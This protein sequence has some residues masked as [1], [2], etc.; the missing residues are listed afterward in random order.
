[1]ENIIY[2]THDMRD[3][4]L[5][6]IFH[7]SFSI[8]RQHTLPNWHENIELLY[9]IQGKGYI[10]CNRE[11]FSFTKGD[12]FVVNANSLH[13]VGSENNILYSCL[14]ID[15][16]F[17]E[18]N[19]LPISCLYF[20]NH[21]HNDRFTSQF[22]QTRQAF[23]TLSEGEE[24]AVSDVRYAV[25][26]LCRLLCRDYVIPPPTGL[27]S[28]ANTHVKNALN[29]IRTHIASPLSLQEIGNA[30]GISKY[31]LAR[32]F[33]SYTGKTIVEMINLIRCNE[34]KALIE[35]G[36][37]VSAAARSCGFENLSYFTRTFKKHYKI[38]PSQISGKSNITHFEE[39]PEMIG[40]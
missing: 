25:L 3:P 5:P 12:V 11:Q 34:A 2:E 36:M 1:M 39:L 33:K 35:S 31:H 28:S 19:G 18:S 29:Y 27:I 32:E 21:I 17:F 37:S 6:F 38:L 20:Q 16:S 13:Y 30:V 26:G 22:E 10:Y 40:C 8:S 4:L 23:N 7:R 14:I 15:N 24:Y 9:C